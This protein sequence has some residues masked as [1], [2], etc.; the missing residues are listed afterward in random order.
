MKYRYLIIPIIFALIDSTIFGQKC[1]TNQ[2]RQQNITKNPQIINTIAMINEY[3]EN[4]I[5][6][7]QKKIKKPVSVIGL[8]I[9]VHILWNSADENVEDS[10]IISQLDVL[11]EDFRKLNANYNITPTQFQNIAADIGVE[12]CLAS[13]DPN[14]NPTSGITRTQTPIYNIGETESWYSSANGG[15]DP[16]DNTK[17]INIWIC[18]VGDEI[19]G[20]ATP[21][22]TA[23]PNSSDGIVIGYKYFGTTGQ[24]VSSAPN[25]LGRTTTHEMGHYLNLEHLWGPNNGGCDEDDYVGDTPL[26]DFETYDCPIFPLFDNCTPNDNGINFNNYMDYTNDDC[27]TMFTEGQ[28]SRM[29]AA[30][31][32]PRA[33]LLNS[34]ICTPLAIENEKELSIFED[35]T[36]Y[37]NPSNHTINITLSNSFTNKNIQLRLIDILGREHKS[38]KINNF[39][40][41]NVSSLPQGVYYLIN[42]QLPKSIKKIIITK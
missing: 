12:F 26:Q 23:Y 18:G 19:L 40:T 14:G 32:G 24:A 25:H 17:Y 16:W 22:G 31:N 7:N 36:I 11:N 6:S 42:D 30:L 8:P 5:N 39:K 20:F 41:I 13:I 10:Q 28:K 3:T 1:L 29:M 27:M 34:N 37:P 35:L 33:S 4:W 21:P 9:V 15:I 2:I 38:F